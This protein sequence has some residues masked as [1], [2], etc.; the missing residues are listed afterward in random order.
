M[1]NSGRGRAG[2]GVFWGGVK[3]GI[4]QEGMFELVWVDNR[5]K[6]GGRWRAQHRQS[7]EAQR[8]K[9]GGAL[10]EVVMKG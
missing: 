2:I 8:W 5:K 1:R 3:P 4:T 10:G 6:R 7:L 9:D